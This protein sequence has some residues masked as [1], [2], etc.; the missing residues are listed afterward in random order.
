MRRIFQIIPHLIILKQLLK[1][2]VLNV[3]N[4]CLNWQTS[5]CYLNVTSNASVCFYGA[6]YS[7]QVVLF[8]IDN[9]IFLFHYHFHFVSVKNLINAAAFIPIILVVFFSVCYVTSGKKKEIIYDTRCRIFS[10]Y[11]ALLSQA[12]VVKL[13]KWPKLMWRLFHRWK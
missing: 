7:M 13:I 11:F 3:W 10:S 5:N 8:L 1:W 9:L 12:I 4:R 6:N 2:Y